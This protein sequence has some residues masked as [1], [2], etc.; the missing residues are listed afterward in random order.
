MLGNPGIGKSTELIIL[1]QQLL[2][3]HKGDTQYPLFINLKNYRSKHQL[4]DLITNKN[5]TSYNK[6]CLIFDSL[7]EIPQIYRIL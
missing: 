2:E 1:M 5:W 4:E 7:Y 3:L 6:V